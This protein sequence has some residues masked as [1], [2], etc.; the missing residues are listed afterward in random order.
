M[1]DL[2]MPEEAEKLW[3][4]AL[5]NDPGHVDAIFNRAIFRWTHGKGTD[6]H[7]LEDLRA[8]PD[9]AQREKLEN[10]AAEMRGELQK[11]SK[12]RENCAD[13]IEGTSNI[14]DLKA[15]D[16]DYCPAPDCNGYIRTKKG[17]NIDNTAVTLLYRISQDGEI[18]SFL[19]TYPEQYTTVHEGSVSRDGRYIVLNNSGAISLYDSKEAKLLWTRKFK[20][21]RAH[22]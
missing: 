11:G 2:G 20:I 16:A 13:K 19:D 8:I 1:L 7:L 22:V 10:L 5:R 14:F 18:C 3:D 4:A 9:S 6:M 21:G 12:H 15:G 17:K